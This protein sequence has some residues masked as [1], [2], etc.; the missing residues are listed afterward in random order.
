[1]ISIRLASSRSPIPERRF[2]M[3]HDL[4]FV[5]DE[6]QSTASESSLAGGSSPIPL[7]A[8]PTYSEM[9]VSVLAA[10]CLEE[11][12]NFRQG[13]PFSDTYGVEL[14]RR[15][16]VQ[17]D[18]DAWAWLQHCLSEV[19]RSWLHRHPSRKAAYRLDSEEN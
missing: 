16:I 4:C 10:H 5:G 9:H 18:H 14:L 13:K 2:Q 8:N 6:A 19:V 7:T 17:G 12:S 11:I 1:M 3:V 15:A